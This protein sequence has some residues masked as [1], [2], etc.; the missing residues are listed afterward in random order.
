MQSTREREKK[1][2]GEVGNDRGKKHSS[3]SNGK[4]RVSNK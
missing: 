3:Q 1:T 4:K 2:R